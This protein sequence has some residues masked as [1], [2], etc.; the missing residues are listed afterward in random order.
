MNYIPI[1]TSQNVKVEFPLA[2][3]SDRAIAYGI[4]FVIRAAY[5]IIISYLLFEVLNIGRV[6]EDQW[7]L[8]AIY[9][10]SMLPVVFYSLVCNMLL[11]GQSI[12]KKIR[13]IQIIKIDG[14]QANF[15]DYFIR[16]MFCLIDIYFSSAF[17]GIMSIVLSKNNQRL[18]G[19]ASG[20]A[21]I[22]LKDDSSINQTILKEVGEEYKPSFQQVLLLNDADMQI[23]KT[24]FESAKSQRDFKVIKKLAQKIKEITQ[25]ET[26]MHDLEF[27]EIIIKDYN[28]YTS[29]MNKD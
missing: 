3:F 7:S 29:Q 15:A 14:Y 16:W 2:S 19:I 10:I 20:T 18:G 12:G 11:E 6:I 13:K 28:F 17:V 21:V 26:E 9:T 24:R 5:S 1:N 4:D 27:V 22:D 25:V 23:I 8:I